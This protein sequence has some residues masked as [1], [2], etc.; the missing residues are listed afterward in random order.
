MARFD[1]DQYQGRCVMHC[2]TKESATTFLSFL[3]SIGKRW[4]S[5]S[6][7]TEFDM[8]YSEDTCYHFLSGEYGSM[9]WYHDE[10]YT[11]LEFYDFEW[12][13]PKFDPKNFDENTA[14]HCPTLESAKIFLNYLD[15]VGKCWTDKV[16]YT[17]KDNW[18]SHR[19]KTVYYFNSGQYCDTDYAHEEKHTVLE[20]DDFDWCETIGGTES[21]TFEEMFFGIVVENQTTV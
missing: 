14:M 4:A 1:F 21:M 18:S 7:Y 13:K 6:R 8:W 17:E 5:G 16:S 3:D 20:F 2:P 12:D 19:D 10:G 9:E 11:I 15:S